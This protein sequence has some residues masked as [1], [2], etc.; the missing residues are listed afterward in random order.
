MSKNKDTKVSL[1]LPKP[2]CPVCGKEVDTWFTRPRKPWI[3]ILCRKHGWQFI[4]KNTKTLLSLHKHSI[5]E[6]QTK[7]K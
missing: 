3:D 7:V 4:R 2:K 5:K 6:A 1:Q